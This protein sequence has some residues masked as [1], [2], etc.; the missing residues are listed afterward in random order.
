M[1]YPL[2]ILGAGASHDFLKIE[3]HEQNDQ[4][5]LRTWKP[6]LTNNIF[7]VSRFS[8]IIGKYEDVKALAST[9]IN[10]TDNDAPFDFEKYL[11]EQE[12]EFAEKSYPQIIALRFYLAE[13]FSKVSYHFYRHTNNHRHLIDQIEKRVGKALV[14]NFN[15]D[16][17]FE[18]NIKEINGSTSVDSYIAGSLKVIKIHGAHNWRYTP[19]IEVGKKDVYDYFV[20]SG[21]KLFD[22]YKKHEI[23]S[24]TIGDIKYSERDRDFDLN[25]YREHKESSFPG[26]A[27][28]YYLPAI[29]IPIA[30]K[31][32]YVCP[33]NHIK[34]M[35]EEL[36]QVDR[37]LVIGWRAQDSF[38]LNE[39]KGYLPNN[40][41]LTIVSSNEASGQAIALN[42]KDISQ[43]GFDN[44]QV[45]P[46]NGYTEFMINRGYER[47]LGN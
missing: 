22:E 23:Y 36:K 30:S 46:H 11:S 21:Q 45:S 3:R 31:G 44:I 19:Q 35:R 28:H 41:R 9:I 13:L 42:F 15:Y 33:D 8:Q 40:V 26:G 1:S 12:V 18:K 32:D 38:I 14:V 10:I 27:F 34:V 47:F 37:V 25:I 6:P 43:I 39:L 17:L 7:D 4:N 2:V 16:T 24:S 20:S 5:S 29:A